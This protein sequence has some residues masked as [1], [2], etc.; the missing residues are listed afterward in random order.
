M[1]HVMHRLL[2]TPYP[3]AVAGDGPYLIDKSGKRYVDAASGAGVSCLGHSASS[4]SDA[5]ARQTKELGYVYNAYFTTDIL[6]RFADALVE[7]TP[8]GLD[9]VFPGS[10]GS[11][12]MDGAL[13]LALQY[14]DEHGEPTRTKFISRRQSYHGCT[15]G[16]LSVSGNRIRRM[17][18]EKF[19]PETI[20]ISPCYEYRERRDDETPQ[21]YSRRLADELD[22]EIERQGPKTVAA[23]IAETVVGATAGCIPPTPDYFRLIRKVCDKHGILLIMDEIL[24]GCGRTGTY[25][26]CEQD[27]VTPDIAVVAKGLGAGYQPLSAILVSGK[28]VDTIAGGRGFFFHGHTYNSHATAAAAGLAVIETIRRQNLLANVRQMSQLMFDRLRARFGNHPNVGD[29]RGRGL[30]I[31]IELVQDRASKKPFSGETMLWNTLQKVAFENGLLCYP[32]FGTA[33]GVD[34]DHILLAPPYIIGS[35]HVEEIVDKLAPSLD[36]AIEMVKKAA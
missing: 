23:F 31:G 26:S 35:N 25:L 16:A 1:S 32:G 36:K 22:A 19:L 5:I 13:K 28:I 34:G 17:L 10:G 27:G 8:K 33:D 6:E 21:A 18:F 24:S 20:Q 11:E 7:M 15:I 2:K 14:H 4:V 12:S 9:W 30:L 3:I 29:I